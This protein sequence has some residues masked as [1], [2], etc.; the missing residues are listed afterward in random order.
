[1]IVLAGML[2]PRETIVFARSPQE[3]NR[4]AIISSLR[5]HFARRFAPRGS[6]L[7][8][9]QQKSM[10]HSFAPLYLRGLL[11]WCFFSSAEATHPA[12]ESK[13]PRVNMISLVTRRL[14]SHVRF[15]FIRMVRK[16]RYIF[17]TSRYLIPIK[18]EG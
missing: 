16:S 11:R 6:R 5:F 3:A 10:T 17:A 13:Y 2:R 14:L 1:M 8:S 9:R 15:L 18:L 12:L 4:R 7:A